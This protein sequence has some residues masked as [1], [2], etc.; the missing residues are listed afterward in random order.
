MI[1]INLLEQDKTT[2]E[3]PKI[4]FGGISTIGVV[5]IVVMLLTFGYIGVSWYTLGNRIETLKQDLA[6]AEEDL[7]EVEQAL[8][9]VDERQAKKDALEQR[10]ALISE[11]KR[12]QR[13]PVH[14]LDQISRQLPEFLWLEGLEERDGGIRVRG[15][16]TT[17]NAVSNFYNNLRDSSFFSDV[18]MGTTQRV[19]EG[20]SFVLSCRFTP[21][22]TG[23][24]GGEDAS[25]D[26]AG[27][28]S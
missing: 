1:R 4:S 23:A 3:G 19:P 7:K 28:R 13:V 8:R 15:K 6:Q 16:A 26:D 24:S 17:F 11:L 20:V 25:S 27:A 14:L 21:P 10:V 12:R 5:W 22:P 18:T 2:K 9:T